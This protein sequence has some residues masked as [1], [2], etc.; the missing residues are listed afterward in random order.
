MG[1]TVEELK[2]Q[3]HKGTAFMLKL[4]LKSNKA[5]IERTV[6][7]LM[8]DENEDPEL[9]EKVEKFASNT[10]PRKMRELMEAVG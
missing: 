6:L 7:K 3:Y 5:F 4:S 8:R 9:I 10:L 1:F 2:K